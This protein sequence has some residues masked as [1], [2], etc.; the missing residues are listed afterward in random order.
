MQF[1]IM[2]TSII[3]QKKF[4]D[5]SS[6]MNMK[7]NQVV[8]NYNSEKDVSENIFLLIKGSLLIETVNEDSYKKH[9]FYFVATENTFFGLESLL[10]NRTDVP[11]FTY[12]I[13]ALTDCTMVQINSQ[14]FLDHLYVNPKI[15]H[16]LFSDTLK[17]YFLLAN[18][19]LLSNSSPEIKVANALLN[20]AMNMNLVVEEEDEIVFP[21]Y[22]TQTFISEYIQSSVANVSRAFDILEKEKII[23]K[24]PLVL[25]NKEIDYEKILHSDLN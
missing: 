23:R 14:F 13:K 1:N 25:I 24:K 12:Q 22:I 7:K 15:Y 4:K 11:N 9:S 19:F 3:G 10:L 8:I 16:K 20:L 6:F 21:K 18:S 5:K 2:T 17:R